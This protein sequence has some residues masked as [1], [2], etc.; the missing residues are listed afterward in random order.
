MTQ[1]L[2]SDKQSLVFEIIS[3]RIEDETEAKKHVI[4]NLQVRHISGNEDLSPSII[5]RRYTNFLNFYESLKAEYPELMNN[6]SFPKKVLLGNFDN[7]LISNR[8]MGFEHLLKYVSTHSML[9]NSLALIS[10]L[11]EPELLKAKQHMKNNEYNLALPL[12]ENIFLLLNKVFTDR[13]SV[14]LISLCRLLGCS[15]LVANAANT[16]KIAELTYHRFDGVSDSELLALYVPVLQ[17]CI[18][19]GLKKDDF[20][21][22]LLD[23]SKTGFKVNEKQSLLMEVDDVEAKIFHFKN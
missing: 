4:Y 14:V 10:F 12:L 17:I 1:I 21:K 15:V 5:E 11:Q 18:Q 16:K 7:E 13:S 19:I 3:A 22:K 2:G 23:L 8:S 6:I 9:R 20:Q